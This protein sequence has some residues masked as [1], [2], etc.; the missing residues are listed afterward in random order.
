M[1]PEIVIQSIPENE[2]ALAQQ[3]KHLFDVL[4]NALGLPCSLSY[5]QDG[6]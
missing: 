6:V 4:W 1:F 5:D 2:H 3:L